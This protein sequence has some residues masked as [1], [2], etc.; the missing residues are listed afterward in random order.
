MNHTARAL[1]IPLDSANPQSALVKIALKP[2][3]STPEELSERLRK[4]YDRYAKLAK[5]IGLKME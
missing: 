1:G 3:V 2:R 5:E 4:D